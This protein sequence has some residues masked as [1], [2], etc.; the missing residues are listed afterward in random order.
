MHGNDAVQA[1]A[2]SAPDEQL[3]VVEPLEVGLGQLPVVVYTATVP[4]R[5]GDPVA[6]LAAPPPEPALTDPPVAVAFVGTVPPPAVVP[7]PVPLAPV[8]PEVPVVPL[9]AGD[10]ELPGIGWVTGGVVVGVGDVPIGRVGVPAGVVGLP[11]VGGVEGWLPTVGS[12][13]VSGGSLMLSGSISSDSGSGPAAFMDSC[14]LRRGPAEVCVV[15]LTGRVPSA[16]RDTGAVVLELGEL[17]DL[18]EP[19]GG[20]L[21]GAKPGE[22]MLR[23]AV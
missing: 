5:M 4:D 19:G 11:S 6:P 14:C 13:A 8:V 16:V 9:V 20:P 3:L 1:G 22:G 17:G 10:P 15:V 18:G 2:P 21:G 23:D 12:V 7:L